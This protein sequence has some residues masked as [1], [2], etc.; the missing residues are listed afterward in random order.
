MAGEEQHDIKLQV[1]ATLKNI[2]RLV[3]DR[4]RR[5]IKIENNNTDSQ[6]RENDDREK[7]IKKCVELYKSELQAMPDAVLDWELE[8]LNS[9]RFQSKDAK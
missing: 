7:K 1:F 3:K 9:H 4:K 8:K 6:V 2:E 5:D